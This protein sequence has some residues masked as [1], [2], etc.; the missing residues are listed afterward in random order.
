MATASY[1]MCK[2]NP[3]NIKKNIQ[4]I[5]SVAPHANPNKVLISLFEDSLNL[6]NQMTQAF[7]SHPHTKV[8]DCSINFAPITIFNINDMKE[9]K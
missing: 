3:L 4:Y 1:L 7:A 8:Y 5:R 2:E 6:E 9:F